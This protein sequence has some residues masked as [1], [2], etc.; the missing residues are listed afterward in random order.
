MILISK[1]T[2]GCLWNLIE[3]IFDWVCGKLNVI[4]LAQQLMFINWLFLDKWAKLSYGNQISFGR[5]NTEGKTYPLRRAY[6]K[7]ILR[8]ASY[9]PSFITLRV[10]SQASMS[11]YFPSL[12]HLR[13]DSDFFLVTLKNTDDKCQLNQASFSAIHFPHFTVIK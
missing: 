7:N 8:P 11:R 2:R 12:L 1:F 5:Q 9:S 3:L 13:A 4:N 10:H 6:C